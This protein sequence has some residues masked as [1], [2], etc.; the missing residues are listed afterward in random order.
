MNARSGKFLFLLLSAV[1]FASP[2][3]FFASCGGGG[4]EKT[5]GGWEIDEKYTRG[6][7]DMRIA[8]DKKELTIAEHLS[9]MIETSAR[10]GYIVELPKFGDKLDQ[11]GIVDYSSPSAK[12]QEDGTVVTSR[13][14]EL[15]PFLSGSYR[16]PPMAVTF[17]Q[18]QDS[19]FHTLESD[20]ITVEVLSLLPEDQAGLELKDIA[21]P[22]SI[23][24]DRRWLYY[25]GA[26]LVAAVAAVLLAIRRRRNRIEEAR[27]IPAH[28][29]AFDRLER[30]LAEGLI[31]QK[32]YAEFT[33]RVSDILRHY[34]EDRFG[35]RAPER[36]TE[37][38]IDEARQWLPVEP[39]QKTILKEFMMHCDLVK[40]A[41]HEPT[42]DEVKKSF[43]TCRD[44]IDSTKKEE[45]VKEEAV[46]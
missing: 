20:T 29:R 13:I 44:F 26:A 5:G 24:H 19:L 4:E 17:R 2:A 36:T 14:Y 43:D 37:E 40:F 41:A 11:F 34:I 27:T 12:L 16:I 21:P 3:A 10:E 28:E 35:L 1:V 45:E 46:K 42:A 32:R 8:I 25:T 7:V 22:V 33:E 15:E 23:P 6:P 9:L 39:E 31:D 18:E 38:F 30:L